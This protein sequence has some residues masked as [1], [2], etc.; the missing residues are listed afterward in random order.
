MVGAT[1]PAGGDAVK[2][3]VQDVRN[4]PFGTIEVDKALQP[5]L[6]LLDLDRKQLL[7]LHVSGSTI[8]VRFLARN[9][10]TKKIVHNARVSVSH[11]I[12][13]DDD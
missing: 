11:K 1:G 8:R 4:E 10:R 3:N 5:L 6:D 12:V 9:S 7:D 2:A 13:R